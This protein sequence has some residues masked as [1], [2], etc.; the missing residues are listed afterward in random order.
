MQDSRV[1]P[2][3]IAIARALCDVRLKDAPSTVQRDCLL[4][5]YNFLSRDP[6]AVQKANAAIAEG[7]AHAFRQQLAA[8]LPETWLLIA[9]AELLPRT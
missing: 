1:L 8:H 7:L 6:P 4:A 3:P 2:G 5:A 9:C